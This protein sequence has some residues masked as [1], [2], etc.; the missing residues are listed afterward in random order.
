MMIMMAIGF[1]M[2]SLIRQTRGERRQQQQPQ[3]SNN[4]LVP[5][6][7]PATLVSSGTNPSIFD[8]DPDAFRAY[9]GPSTSQQVSLKQHRDELR[10]RRE[11]PQ[12]QPQL[13][14]QQ[15][16]PEERYL[17]SDAINSNDLSYEAQLRSNLL[18]DYDRNS[19]P[20]EILWTTDDDE[21]DVGNENGEDDDAAP[22][23]NRTRPRPLEVEFGMNFHKVHRV[24]VADATVDLLVWIRMI[25]VD[26]RLA[27]DPSEYGNTTETWMWLDKGM[28]AS[29]SSVRLFVCLR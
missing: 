5:R 19:F 3:P 20:W 26:P 8:D 14:Q 27:W 29:E 21:Y 12:Q 18:M 10:R 25:W 11:Q 7:H 15:R 6:I 28:G 22:K 9:I 13:Q 24:D 2:L 16:S 23:T 17:V 1:L 4:L